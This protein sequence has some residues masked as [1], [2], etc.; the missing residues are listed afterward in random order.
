MNTSTSHLI[1]LW[2][3]SRTRLEQQLDAIT[4]YDLR[5][6]LAPSP[7]SAGFLL[8]HIAEVE[9]LFAKN[10]FGASEVKIIAH[11]VIDKKDTG[12]W[13]DASSIKKTLVTSRKTLH[14]IINSQK[15]GNWVTVI[16]TKEFGAKT[17]AEALGRIISHTAYHAGQLS[18]L[19]KY[20]TVTDS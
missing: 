3:E 5:K 7:N 6:K 9:L 14:E 2:A 17:K 16:Q 18:L 19:L 11:T 12:Q 8:Q 15:K 13:T 20:G 10:V 1:D 4:D